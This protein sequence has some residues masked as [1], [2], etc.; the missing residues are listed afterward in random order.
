MANVLDED[1]YFDGPEISEDLDLVEN[2]PDWLEDGRIEE[3]FEAYARTVATDYQVLL[4]SFK[5][6]VALGL[7]EKDAVREVVELARTLE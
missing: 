2:A 5:L 6:L 3:E 1:A 7:V 4:R